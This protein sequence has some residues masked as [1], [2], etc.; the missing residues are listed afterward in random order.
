M[1]GQ[2]G[3]GKE[4]MLNL[5]ISFSPVTTAPQQMRYVPVTAVPADAQQS[6]VVQAQEQ[7]PPG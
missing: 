7:G 5:V 2:Q 1:S 3:E 4:G 6:Q